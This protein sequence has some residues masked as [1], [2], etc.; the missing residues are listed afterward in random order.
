MPTHVVR[1]RTGHSYAA[2][3]SEAALTDPASG[4][5]CHVLLTRVP[6]VRLRD[7]AAATEIGR[8]D[9]RG[10]LRVFDLM[11]FSHRSAAELSLLYQSADLRVPALLRARLPRAVR[12]KVPRTVALPSAPMRWDPASRRFHITFDEPVRFFQL[13]VV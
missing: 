8:D 11:G 10:D 3:S 7:V 9:A 12:A 4:A 6:R 13:A 2:S 5:M 1:T